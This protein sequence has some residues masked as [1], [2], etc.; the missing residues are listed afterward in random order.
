M[1]ELDT[2]ITDLEQHEE[3]G[4]YGDRHDG[5]DRGENGGNNVEHCE[6]NQTCQR[7]DRQR[8]LYAHCSISREPVANQSK[9]A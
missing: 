6:G 5:A 8:L 2:M 9:V 7:N 1:S 3:V 4:Q